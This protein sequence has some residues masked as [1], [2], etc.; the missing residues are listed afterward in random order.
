MTRHVILILI[1]IIF[2]PFRCKISPPDQIQSSVKHLYCPVSP[3]VSHP[4]CFKSVQ[5][6]EQVHDEVWGQMCDLQLG[7]NHY[8]SQSI[9]LVSKYLTFITKEL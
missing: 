5:S 1:I 2:F 8:K 4:L 9:I 7:V 3:S 6:R